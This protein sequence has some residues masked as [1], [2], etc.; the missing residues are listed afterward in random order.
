MVACVQWLPM[1][2][3]I[4]TDTDTDTNINADTGTDPDTDSSPEYLKNIAVRLLC[5]DNY[6]TAFDF[7][8]KIRFL[9]AFKRVLHHSPG[10]SGQ[11]PGKLPGDSDTTC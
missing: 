4:D 9:Q 2:T 10:T 3:C 8:K 5:W 6:L 7:R 1:V 11:E